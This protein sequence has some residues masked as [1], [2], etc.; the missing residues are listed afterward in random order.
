MMIGVIAEGDALDS[1]VAE[2]FGHAPFFL[3]VDVDTLDYRVV[4]NEF[5]DSEGAGFK[6]AEAIAGLKVDAVIVGG[7]GP[8][9]LHIL[10]KAGIQV[11][12]DEDGTVERCVRDF[13]RRYE[14]KKKFETPSD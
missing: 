7:I 12:Y 1:Y 14:L 4:K 3:I 9:G 8:H 5:A 13:K 10:N 11:S 2:D 6:V